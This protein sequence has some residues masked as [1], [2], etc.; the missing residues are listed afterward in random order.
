MSTCVCACC[1][2][3]IVRAAAVRACVGVAAGPSITIIAWLA[4]SRHWR[5]WHCH[6]CCP[7]CCCGIHCLLRASINQVGCF[8]VHSYTW[9]GPTNQRDL[10]QGSCCRWYVEGPPCCPYCVGVRV[11]EAGCEFALHPPVICSSNAPSE[12]THKCRP[13]RRNQ[14]LASVCIS[15]S[16]A[17]QSDSDSLPKLAVCESGFWRVSSA[18]CV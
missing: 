11:Y 15:Q 16:S 10:K 4:E 12:G 14:L 1:I 7:H 18:G 13:C 9:V 8:S 6:R 17:Q 5:E 3:S 2:I